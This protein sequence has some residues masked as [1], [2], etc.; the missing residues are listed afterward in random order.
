MMIF[1]WSTL[2][3]NNSYFFSNNAAEGGVVTTYYDDPSFNISNSIF[4]NN[5]ATSFGGVIY[6]PGGEF[7]INNCNFSSNEVRTIGGGLLFISQC[8]TNIA[9]SKFDHNVGSI[10]T[11]N[12]NLNFSGNSKLKNSTEPFIAG[13]ESTSQEGGV[14]TSFQSTVTFTEISETNN[15]LSC[16][17]RDGGAILA[18]ESTIIMHGETTIANNNLI[19]FANSRGGGISLIQSHLEIKGKC[20]LVNNSAVRGGGIHAT[21][22]TV[23]V[24]TPGTLQII[25]NY[26]ELGGG[27]NLELNSKL[28][29]LKSEAFFTIFTNRCFLNF[30][31]NHA[32]YGGA[33]YVEDST[34]PGSCS[35][36]SEC[37]IQT[38]ALHR[39]QYTYD[40][41]ET[42]N[43]LFSKNTISEQGSDLFGGL[44]D[45]CKPS[46]F[47][48]VYRKQ[49]TY[50]SGVNYFQ[51]I[52][53]SHRHS[54]SSRP[55]RVCFCNSE[56]QPDCSY[57]LPTINVKKGEAFNVSVVAVNQVDDTVD[58]NI[59]IS[60]PPDGGI[61]EGQQT[62]I[63]RR[64]C[65]DMTYNVFSP[66][67]TET[68]NLFADGPCGSADAST[69]HIT[70]HFNDCTCSVGF[71]PLYVSELST[72]CE[73][74]CDSKLSPYITN[75]NYS[76]NS[77]F[78]METDSW[79]TYIDDTNLS[80][81][82]IYANC[83]FDYCKPSTTIVSINFNILNGAD[84]QC[85]YNRTGVLCGSCGENLS[86]SLASSRC[87]PCH[88]HWPAVCI[89]ILMAAILAGIL[90]VTALLV[91]NMTVSVGLVNCF[92][93]YANIVSA[94]SAV[95]FPSTEPS[96]PSVFVAWLNLDI[97]IDVCFIDGLDANIKTWLQLFFSF[98]YHFSCCHGSHS[99]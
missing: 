59:S 28:Y 80:G 45:R 83:P 77:V 93:F 56:H 40:N 51:N 9:N 29:V 31:D 14:I 55:V 20:N 63:V 2:T 96:F 54:I 32:N 22:S 58:A 69:S 72:R 74:D 37:F 34:N 60:S 41:P 86:L 94:G 48:E 79:I 98:V 17:A 5:S 88:S 57:Q 21:S 6:C 3:I 53:N 68:I 85:A 81:Y 61:G 73:C 95:F 71:E 24:Y 92:I 84:I 36:D 75:C 27:M 44:L 62:Q 52:S 82:V 16:Q 70:I 89:V 64:D 30:T 8:S 12:S 78:R 65:T 47:A 91:L 76:T 11:F 7:D 67:D 15:I 99:E 13:N 90:L 1:G 39:Y 43:I 87:L 46:P 66:H 50:Y 97:G 4:T 26:A 38:L 33:V 25:N 10:Y 49:E 18:I 35:S 42:V 19:T 23:A